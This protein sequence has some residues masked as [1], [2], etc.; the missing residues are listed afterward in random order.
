M[1]IRVV[2]SGFADEAAAVVPSPPIPP[3]PIL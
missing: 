3:P 1:G 2:D